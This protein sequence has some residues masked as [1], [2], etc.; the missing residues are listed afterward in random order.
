MPECVCVFP[1]KN[2]SLV[3]VVT[4][5]G[6]DCSTNVRPVNR[7]V[8]KWCGCQWDDLQSKVRGKLK[9]TQVDLEQPAAALWSS[10]VGPS[11]LWMGQSYCLRASYRKGRTLWYV[12]KLFWHLFWVYAYR[13]VTCLYLF[14]FIDTTMGDVLVQAPQHNPVL[15]H[16]K[17]WQCCE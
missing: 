10:C 8:S 5:H 4:L 1:A 13:N 15:L 16:K 14:C 11:C 6:K 3:Q 7:E 2:G 9:H 12:T 17:E